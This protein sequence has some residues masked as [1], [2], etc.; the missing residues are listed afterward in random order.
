MKLPSAAAAALAAATILVSPGPLAAT[1]TPTI[2][3]EVP[4]LLEARAAAMGVEA[5]AVATMGEALHSTT[6]PPLLREEDEDRVEEKL[7]QKAGAVVV[8]AGPRR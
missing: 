2:A 7:V 3:T 6:S 8:E 1:T 4:R 5:L